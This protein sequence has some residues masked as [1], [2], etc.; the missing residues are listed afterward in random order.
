M[1]AVILVKELVHA[2]IMAMRRSIAASI[3]RSSQW[4]AIACETH[5]S[6]QVDYVWPAQMHVHMYTHAHMHRDDFIQARFNQA[7]TNS[8]FATPG[9]ENSIAMAC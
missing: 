4:T 3:N 8:T 6:C 5:N 7:K 9:T 2:L 1:F